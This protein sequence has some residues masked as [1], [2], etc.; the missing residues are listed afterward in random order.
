MCV[1]MRSGCV[2][3]VPEPVDVVVWKRTNTSCIPMYTYIAGCPWPVI[4]T[5]N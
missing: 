4:F 2:Y 1:R 3:C 5:M